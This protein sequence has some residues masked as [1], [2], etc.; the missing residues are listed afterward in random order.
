MPC[1]EAFTTMKDPKRVS[2]GKRSKRKG[3]SN[4]NALAKLFSSWWG[5]GE[6][7]RTPS[8]G[9]WSTANVREAFRTCGDIITTAIDF[10]YCVEAKKAE[11]WCLEQLLTAPKSSLFQWWDQT[12]SETPKGLT[13]MLVAGRNRMERLVIVREGDLPHPVRLLIEKELPHFVFV[14]N[15]DPALKLLVFTLRDLFKIP[16]VMLGKDS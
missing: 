7:A 10:K 3:S 1:R 12:V 8:S 14:R 6:W 9:G 15:T 13:P 16:P 5:T 2:A 4:E 11:G